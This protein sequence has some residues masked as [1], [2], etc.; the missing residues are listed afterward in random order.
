MQG[1]VGVTDID[2]RDTTRNPRMRREIDRLLEEAVLPIEGV[3]K[4]PMPALTFR[5]VPPQRWQ[6][7]VLE[8]VERS[9]ERYLASQPALA[10]DQA[11]CAQVREH[12]RRYVT[13][14]A[15]RRGIT[16]TTADGIPHTLIVPRAL[17]ITEVAKALHGLHRFVVQEAV[18][19]AQIYASRGAVAPP[20]VWACPGL[21]RQPRVQDLVDGHAIW[22]QRRVSAFLFDTPPTT[23]PQRSPGH[24][25]RQPYAQAV[26]AAG[27]GPAMPPR[28]EPM[29]ESLGVGFV[30]ATLPVVRAERWNKKVW[31][32]LDMVPTDQELRRPE[33]WLRRV[34]FQPGERF[35]GQ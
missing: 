6:A 9:L 10:Q 21:L 32:A 26:R 3:T 8:Y 29:A 18:R 22:A 7:E 20:P 23:P 14:W 25:W 1:E 31:G 27:R 34:G 12:W 28:R 13:S 35:D 33:A 2:V 24:F 19:Q 5:L 11:R 15:L 4:L 17:Q 16:L 30:G